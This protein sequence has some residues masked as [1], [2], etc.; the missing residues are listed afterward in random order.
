[1]ENNINWRD[2]EKEKPKVPNKK[3]LVRIRSRLH[4]GHEFAWLDDELGWLDFKTDVPL[5]YVTHFAEI[6]EP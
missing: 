3:M 4:L 1:M 2:A 6:N 5:K